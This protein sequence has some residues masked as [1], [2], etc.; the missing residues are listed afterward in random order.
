[1]AVIGCTMEIDSSVSPHSAVVARAGKQSWHDVPACVC[2]LEGTR[3]CQLGEAP[4]G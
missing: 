4:V 3:I 2:K 1:M